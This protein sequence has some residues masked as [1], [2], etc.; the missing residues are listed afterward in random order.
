MTRIYLG[1]GSNSEPAS[2]LRAAV[3][4]LERVFGAV[5][6]SGVYRTAAV[7]VPAPDYL[8][9]VIAFD[10]H[11]GPDAVKAELV[12]VEAA[13]G[14]RRETA[15][16]AVC[17][18]DLDLLFCGARVDAPRRLP[19]PDVL[20]RAFVLA[21]LAEVAPQLRHPVTGER[22][23]SAWHRL[24]GTWPAIEKVGAIE[25]VGVIETVE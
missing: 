25:T 23:A 1:A 22:L 19:H 7:G 24:G 12:A 2:R 15:R 10:S 16:S 11:R 6:C 8:N 20:R 18:I 21:P 4:A 5:R 9:L 14:R 13:G 17:T 3:A